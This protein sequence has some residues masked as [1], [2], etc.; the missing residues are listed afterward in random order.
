M[1]SFLPITLLAGLALAA[2]AAAAPAPR[3]A[4]ESFSGISTVKPDGTGRKLI[5]KHADAPTWSPDHERV[6]YVLKNAI[7][8]ARADG[9]DRRRVITLRSGLPF[10]P[11][12]SPDGK[13]I[14]YQ[15]TTEV[16]RPGADDGEVDEVNAVFTVRTNGTGRRMV[17][18][19]ESPAWTPTGNHIVLAQTRRTSS[20][21]FASTIGIVKPDGKGYRSLHTSDSYIPD[22]VVQP[23][24]RR[25]A[26]IQSLGTTAIGVFDR[27]TNR[28]KLFVKSDRTALMDIAW[29]PDGSRIAWLQHRISSH[30][31]PAPATRLYTV[32]PDGSGQ[33]TQFSFPR[34]IESPDSLAW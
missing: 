9:T 23:S 25:I 10:D 21:G 31:G 20:G 28:N 24:G 2:P 29:T 13:R 7:W 11:A 26:Y 3:I 17:H 14:A 22:L 5:V 6:A 18:A 30:A 12:W 33:R 8:T 27:S 19:G 34:G 15:Q 4:Y 16:R 1:R 32:R